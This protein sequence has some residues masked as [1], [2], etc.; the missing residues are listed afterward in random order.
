MQ[1]DIRLA[2]AES[3]PKTVDPGNFSAVAR[4]LARMRGYTWGEVTG[5][6]RSVGMVAMRQ[7][8]SWVGVRRCAKSFSYVAHIMN[9]DHTTVI[10]SVRK[11]DVMIARLG[12]HVGEDPVQAGF[13]LIMA[14]CAEVVQNPAAMSRDSK[15]AA[16]LRSSMAIEIES[17]AW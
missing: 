15:D 1:K 11:V 16:A 6:A 9:R 5:D 13:T 2:F 14:I 3:L 12:L 17:E 4:E 8:I 10:Y 7:A